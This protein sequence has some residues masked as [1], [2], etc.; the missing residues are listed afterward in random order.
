VLEPPPLPVDPA[1]VEVVLALELHA[2]ATRK[3]NANARLGFIPTAYRF[4]A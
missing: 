3:L 4:R 2:A 1:D